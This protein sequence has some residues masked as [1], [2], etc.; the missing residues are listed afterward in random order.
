MLQKLTLSLTILLVVSLFFGCQKKADIEE[1]KGGSTMSGVALATPILPGKVDAWREWSRELEEEPRSSDY[2]AIMKKAGLSR[3]R[4]WLQEGP[5]GALAIMVYEGESPEAFLQEIATSGEDF[6]VWFRE[7][8]KD[9]HG[10]DLAESKM[11]LS[12]LINDFHSD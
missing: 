3:I 2:I 8:I 12:E 10:Y 4:V 11:P 6:S 7:K 9:L 5:E 1:E